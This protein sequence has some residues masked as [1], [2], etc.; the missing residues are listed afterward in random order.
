MII[1]LLGTELVVSN[2]DT[3]NEVRVEI[4]E[5]EKVV[6]CGYSGGGIATNVMS[7]SSFVQKI[8]DD[9]NYSN[10]EYDYDVDFYLQVN[11]GD[12]LWDG[13]HVCTIN[14]NN[15]M[16]VQEITNQINEKLMELIRENE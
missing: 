13:I 3:Y 7:L 5:E 4:G 2:R 8:L 9:V 10:L 1:K 12:E 15:M 11:F 6:Y 16:S 14:H